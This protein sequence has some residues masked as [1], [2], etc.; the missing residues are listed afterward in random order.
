EYIVDPG[1]RNTLIE[2]DGSFD[3]VVSF[4]VPAHENSPRHRTSHRPRS[5]CSYRLGR[6]YIRR[7]SSD[8]RLR[9]TSPLEFAPVFSLPVIPL[10]ARGHNR[11]QA[12]TQ[13]AQKTFGML[14]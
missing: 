11:I 6:Q 2:G 3:V 4:H 5:G 14:Q 7:S 1:G 9:K 8:T 12:S 13:A 10:R